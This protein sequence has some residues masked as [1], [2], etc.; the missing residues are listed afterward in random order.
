MAQEPTCKNCRWA[1]WEYKKNGAVN[2][3]YSGRCFWPAPE[4]NVTV[5]ASWHL[6]LARD[7]NRQRDYAPHV[8]WTHPERNCKTWE[9]V[10]K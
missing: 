2:S 8:G 7:Y 5:P 1:Q 9:K 3:A 6:D 4:L 10:Q